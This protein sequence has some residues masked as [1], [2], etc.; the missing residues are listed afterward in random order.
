MVYKYVQHLALTKKPQREGMPLPFM[1]KYKSWSSIM[2][3]L[4]SYVSVALTV[5]S[6]TIVLVPCC[7]N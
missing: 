2:F 1:Y 6:F 3:K 5:S 7:L 4:S